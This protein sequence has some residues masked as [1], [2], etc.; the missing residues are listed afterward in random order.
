M[1]YYWFMEFGNDTTLFHTDGEAELKKRAVEKTLNGSIYRK[2]NVWNPS[3][4][5][6]LL[7][8]EELKEF[9]N[10]AN[11]KMRAVVEG[12]TS[13]NLKP[14]TEQM[15]TA[16]EAAISYEGI[17]I[18]ALG[19]QETK[20][21]EYMVQDQRRVWESEPHPNFEKK[22]I[23]RNTAATS[24]R[25]SYVE[26][27][28][29]ANEDSLWSFL[30]MTIEDIKRDEG[31]T[32]D[33]RNLTP[34]QAVYLVNY[35]IYKRMNYEELIV[36]GDTTTTAKEI[37]TDHKKTSRED[38]LEL[39]DT[40]PKK[41]ETEV[42]KLRQKIDKMS[43]DEL[44][45]YQFGVC[46][47]LAAMAQKLYEV[48]KKRQEGLLMNGSYLVYHDE[49][50]GKQAGKGL[51][52]DHAYNVLVVT[53]PKGRNDMEMALSVTDPTSALESEEVDFTYKRISQAISFLYEY[54]S[55]LDVD[56]NRAKCE[57]LALMAADRLE[58]YMISHKTIYLLDDYASLVIQSGEVAKQ[59][60]IDKLKSIFSV[61][62]LGKVEFLN[63]LFE[64]PALS[65]SDDESNRVL[66]PGYRAKFI[67]EVS[68]FKFN[69]LLYQDES[70]M[71]EKRMEAI[72]RTVN[73]IWLDIMNL[74]NWGKFKRKLSEKEVSM[75]RLANEVIRAS[76]ELGQVPEV[77]TMKT[78]NDLVEND[79][80]L[81]FGLI[82]MDWVERLET[83]ISANGTR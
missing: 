18:M 80:K 61:T 57:H 47:H 30:E 25:E 76:V 1:L 26:R 2:D 58:K 3:H 75:F 48:L 67:E 22:V 38:L 42:K 60:V 83:I 54:G 43:A 44:L 53:S 62:S 49:N 46:R 16:R 12:F 45:E 66:R 65:S 10:E 5:G 71:L 13:V 39:A 33:I 50:I 9:G 59:K 68:H 4:R 28:S 14:L 79:R 37:I 29:K 35:L 19:G 8:D 73:S 56:D 15:V 74:N 69:S 77:E 41:L 31:E 11:S 20:L 24:R 17:S 32:F 72:L 36:G 70:V 7:T 40:E 27:V 81:G 51:I 63:K 64:I 52:E 78:V 6:N 23:E 21:S 34:F 55:D 82:N